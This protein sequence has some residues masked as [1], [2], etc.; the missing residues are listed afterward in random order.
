MKIRTT[1]IL[2]LVVALSAA[3]AA[4]VAAV[5][6]AP[7]LLSPANGSS[8]VTPFTISWSAV[9]DPSGILGYNWQVSSSSS[10]ATLVKQD[11]V[12]DPTTQ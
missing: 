4:G 2:L 11:S 12:N 1:L 5:P 9:S 7:T 8:I 10:F 3:R 6:V